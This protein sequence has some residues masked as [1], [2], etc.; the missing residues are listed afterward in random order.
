MV[1][2]SEQPYK[3]KANLSVLFGDDEDAPKNFIPLEAISLPAK[4]PR[5]YF[6]DR[7]M[8]SLV[9]SIKINGV[10]QP[11][12]VRPI[13]EDK[14]E[15]VAGERRY[16]GAKIV[17][18]K[19][20]PVVIREL[21]EEQA[22]K[23]ALIENL[24]RENLNPIEETEGTLELLA[25]QLSTSTNEVMKLLYSM[26]NDV[27]RKKDNVI[28]QPEA[29][30]IVKAFDELSS[31]GWESFATNRLPLLKLPE[32][33]LEALRQGRIEY[34]KTRAIAK[35]KDPEARNELLEIA[36][37]EGLSL[38]EIKKRVAEIKKAT[39][40]EIDPDAEDDDEETDEAGDKPDRADK[41]ESL[42]SEMS[43]VYNAL[44]KSKV[45][46]NKEKQDQLKKILEDM[47][48]L[49]LDE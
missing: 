42:K 1:N 6:D 4:Q 28:L 48:S 45:W 49:L 26:K 23:I 13:G 10:L 11:I 29:E 15:L 22:F 2:K 8:Q 31:M 47:E 5:R 21:T 18:L 3:A 46:K 36:I 38:K 16:R 43:K 33:I 25:I 19:E 32:E 24:Q 7:S 17:G 20:I 30:T 39:E 37:A 35:I 9:D 12:L 27:A 40:A 41:P 14:Y 34:T 44:K